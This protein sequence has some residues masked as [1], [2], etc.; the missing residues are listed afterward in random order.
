LEYRASLSFLS[1]KV[2]SLLTA[3]TGQ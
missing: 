1:G 3:I 2:R